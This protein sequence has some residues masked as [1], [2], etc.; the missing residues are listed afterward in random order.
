M[1]TSTT[2]ETILKAARPSPGR[3]INPS[4]RQMRAMEWDAEV[5]IAR[6]LDKMRRDMLRG[7]T[8][9][10]AHLLP[11][12]VASRDILQPF[13]DSMIAVLRDIA[14]AGS[15]FGQEQINRFVFGVRKQVGGIDIDWEL[16]NIGAEDWARRYG[17]DL[18][19]GITRTTQ[20]RLQKEIAAWVNNGDSLGQLRKR[21]SQPNGPFSPKRAR[22]IAVT[23]TTRAF[24]EGNVV[25]WKESGVVERRRW[26][27][28]VDEL[29]CPICGPLHNV[30]TDIDKPF[31]GGLQNPPAHPYCRCWVTPVV[32]GVEELETGLGQYGL[33]KVYK[34][35]IDIMI[36]SS[37]E[38]AY[39]TALLDH[40]MYVQEA[41][42]QIGVDKAQL[43]IHDESK[44]SAEEFGP[45]ANYFYNPDGSKKDDPT[46]EDRAKFTIAWLHHFHNNPH[47]WQSW[48]I[49]NSLSDSDVL[50]M[51][52]NFALEMIA[53]WMGASMSY[54]GTWDMAK[55]LS[56]NIQHI[57]LHQE[58]AAYVRQELNKLGYADTAI[59]LFANGV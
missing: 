37:A 57:T 4:G 25:A 39:M 50:K 55:W 40:I 56:E 59:Q 26:N 42:E 10:N 51:P 6:A 52:D 1:L 24:A 7:L 47:H 22:T 35:D 34:K 43:A 9:V 19:R 58:T 33:G 36:T 15:E 18:V 31:P 49:P 54:Q 32:E 14:L 16:A 46:D 29:V 20:Q 17:F 13:T 38:S 28:S 30:I 21:L 44:F 45:Y 41:G 5:R 48:M 2:G 23:E 3:G 27:T 11:G 53:D 12:R 8:A